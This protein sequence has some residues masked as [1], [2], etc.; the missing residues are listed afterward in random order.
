MQKIT[1]FVASPGDT[2]EE[3]D[4]L[5]AVIDELNRGIAAE[6]QL[7]VELQ[8]WET[9]AWPAIGVDAQEVINREIAI[10]DV[11][12]VILWKRLG[13]PTSRAAS[14]TVEEFDRIF[15]A[16]AIGRRC[17]ILVY[18]NHAPYFPILDELEQI[19]QVL[20]FRERVQKLGA[21]TWDFSG[22]NEFRDYVRNHLTQVIRR[23]THQSRVKVPAAGAQKASTPPSGEV[24]GTWPAHIQETMS[25]YSEHLRKGLLDTFIDAR[26]RDIVEGLMANLRGVLLHK[27]F[28]ERAV[29]GTLTATWLEFCTFM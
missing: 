20:A 24:L 2:G 5:V 26:N 16:Q 25:N 6:R 8:R 7:F 11:L 4:S 19:K 14:G 27:H 15:G 29:R 22:T 9:H 17:E 10:P 1:V 12:V 18:F 28:S 23:W 21:L 3:R 13:T